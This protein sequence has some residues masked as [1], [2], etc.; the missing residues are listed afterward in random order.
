MIFIVAGS[1]NEARYHA[2]DMR[3]RKWRYLDWRNITRIY[4]VENPDVIYVG[5]WRLNPDIENI[6]GEVA[7][8]C[9]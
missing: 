6:Q 1:F 3:I 9:R 5:N 7:A 2:D 4:G 8:R